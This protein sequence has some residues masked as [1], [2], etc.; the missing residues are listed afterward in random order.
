MTAKHVLRN[1]IASAL[2]AGALASTSATADTLLFPVLSAATNIL[3]VMSVINRTNAGGTSHLNYIYRTKNATTPSGGNNYDGPCGTG[4]GGVHNTQNGDLVSFDSSSQL[5]GGNALFGDSGIYGGTFGIGS[6]TPTR[7]YLLVTHANSAGA[8]Q[9]VGSNR[10]LA[11]EF[12]NLDIAGGAAWGG[13]AINDST[14]EDY[15]FT[16]A[17]A[18]G[19]VFPALPSQGFSYRSFAFFPPVA[20]TTRFYVTPIGS[21]MDT[22][23]LTATVQLRSTSN[24]YDRNGILRVFAAIPVQVRCTGMIPLQDLVESA[25]WAALENT[26]GWSEFQVSTADAIVYKLEYATSATYGGTVN[27]GY[28]LSENGLP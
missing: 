4:L 1:A 16:N 5:L 9:S 17:S 19:G 20:F 14:R 15:T 3:T 2:V 24:F 25:T 11:G 13:R 8:R 10:D 6:A 7:G 12:V 22:G 18:G 27:N 21:S 28:L 23:N 26:G